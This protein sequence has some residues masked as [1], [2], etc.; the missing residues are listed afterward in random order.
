MSTKEIEQRLH[1]LK[2]DAEQRQAR[3][4]KK[5]Q[6]REEAL[7]SQFSEQAVELQNQET[8]ERLAEQVQEDLIAI[9]AALGRVADG[10]YDICANCADN[11]EPARLHVLP[12]TTVC[13]DCAD[14]AA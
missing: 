4:A 14:D 6:H 9:E 12:T 3:L 11:I 5:V 2:A 8:M 1:E 7:P 10:S 13:A